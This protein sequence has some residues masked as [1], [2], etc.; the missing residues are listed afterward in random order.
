MSLVTFRISD[1]FCLK[2]VTTCDAVLE[3]NFFC[4]MIIYIQKSEYHSVIQ[5]IFNYPNLVL[6]CR[7]LSLN[8]TLCVLFFGIIVIL[9]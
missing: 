6:L 7:Y 3:D 8:M 9:P 1:D 5:N 4:Y 2:S